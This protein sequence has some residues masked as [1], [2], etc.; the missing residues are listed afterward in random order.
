MRRPACGRGHLAEGHGGAALTRG[1]ARIEEL[2]WQP[3]R[4]AAMRRLA[5]GWGFPADGHGEAAP[6]FAWVE[7]R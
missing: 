2:R 3:R 1:A 5:C 6:S 4:P 7:Q